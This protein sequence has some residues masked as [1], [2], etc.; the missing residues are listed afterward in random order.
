MLKNGS[1]KSFCRR[2]GVIERIYEADKS[3]DTKTIDEFLDGEDDS[4]RNF[5]KK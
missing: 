4:I 2:A 3:V 1:F 5:W